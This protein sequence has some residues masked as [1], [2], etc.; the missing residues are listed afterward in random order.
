MSKKWDK[1]YTEATTA[2]LVCRKLGFATLKSN[3]NGE[4]H[5][6]MVDKI[7][8]LVDAQIV[9]EQKNA[10]KQYDKGWNHGMI[11]GWCSAVVGMI[12]GLIWLGHD[13][14]KKEIPKD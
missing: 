14:S 11:T 5:D 4:K 10:E 9:L 1:E 8:D 3:K 2:G 7:D 13:A 6:D 12:L